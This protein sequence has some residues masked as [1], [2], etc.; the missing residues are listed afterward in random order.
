VPGQAAVV[1]G[2]EAEWVAQLRNAFWEAVLDGII[3]G[4]TEADGV[5]KPLEASGKALSRDLQQVIVFYAGV[6]VLKNRLMDLKT[7][8]AAQAGPV[9]YET[10][11][12]AQVL[13]GLLDEAVRRRNIW[14]E[15]LSDLGVTDSYYIDA[16]TARTE[17]VRWGDLPY[18]R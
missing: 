4:Y 8:F 17:S 11:Q 18:L 16:V 13:R 15:R 9:R 2:T 6:R 14:L 1:G 10:E 3:V 5:V 7:R 12:S